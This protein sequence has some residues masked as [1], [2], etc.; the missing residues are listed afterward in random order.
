MERDGHLMFT[1][2][3]NATYVYRKLIL[4]LAVAFLVFGGVWGTGVF[5]AM[6]GGGFEDKGSESYQAGKVLDDTLPASGADIVALYHSDTLTVDDPTFKTAVTNALNGVNDARIANVVSYYSVGGSL[7]ALV[8]QDRHSTYAV[9]QMTG[10]DDE[11]TKAYTRVR[12]QFAAPPLTV[13]LGG[14]IPATD[15]ISAQVPKDIERAELLTFPAV[16]ILLVIIFGGLVAA[17]LPLAIGGIAILGAFTMLRLITLVTDVSIFAANIVTIIGLGLAI[18]YA[19]FILSRFREELPKHTTTQEAVAR[20]IATA[21]RTVAFSGLTVAISL[22]SLLIFPQVFLRSMGMGGIAAVLIAM[23]AALTLLPAVLSMLG[24]RVNALHLGKRQASL[25]PHADQRATAPLSP[26]HGWWYRVAQGVMRHP[27]QY[28]AVIVVVLALMGSPFLGAR[29]STAGERSLPTNAEARIVSETINSQFPRNE[30]TPIKLAVRTTGDVL[31]PANVAALY[32]YTQRLQAIPGVRRVE[33]VTTIVPA[34]DKQAAVGLLTGKNLDPRLADRVHSL[35]A[36]NTTE[37]DIF[38]DADTQSGD[39]QHLVNTLRAT[40]PPTGITAGATG[41]TAALVDLFAS[42]RGHLPVMFL[43]IV[44]VTFVLLFLAFGSVVVPLKA[45]VLNFLSLTAS[46]GALVLIFQDGHLSGLLHFTSSGDLDATSPIL[47]F[48]ILFGLSMDYEVFL[49]SRIKEA[50]DATGDNTV[51]VATGLQRTGR[52]ITS[53]ALLLMIV[54]G[55]FSTS[56]IVFIKMIGVGMFIAIFVDA[57]IVRTLLVPATMGLMGKANWW[58][59]KPLR[60]LWERIGFSETEAPEPHTAPH[61]F[62][63]AD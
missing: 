19:L 51:A 27:V 24:P 6:V 53:A 26:S 14:N 41:K 16:A 33:S 52:I 46:F 48:A 28:I 47:M 11:K 60:R 63:A 38:Y 61:A 32:D 2:I 59:P 42:L 55:A 9:V 4:A 39:A 10:T 54:I 36:G 30:T 23:L 29:F 37:M 3:G 7:P 15:A 62:I 21:G 56:Q 45:V 40:P 1:R 20:T 50:Y 8:S 43:I 25:S 49:L 5:K 12:R 58:A 34:L 22:S 31:A 35:A 18:D 57:T 17:S 13:Q 44:L